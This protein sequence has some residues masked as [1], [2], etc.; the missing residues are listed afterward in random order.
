MGRPAKG[1]RLERR[2][3]TLAH[4]VSCANF[5][6]LR[7]RVSGCKMIGRIELSDLPKTISGK[8]RRVE[9]RG[10]ESGRPASGVRNGREFL[11][12]MVRG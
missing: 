8:I 6:F 12:E 2:P 7:S 5:A 11:E 9:L 1:L 10:L 4:A 3:F